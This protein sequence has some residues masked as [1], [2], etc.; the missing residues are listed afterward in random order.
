MPA[1]SRPRTSSRSRAVST[2]SAEDS[3]SIRLASRPV[4]GEEAAHA[5]GE[6]EAIVS[7]RPRGVLG[8]DQGGVEP[9]ELEADHPH[10]TAVESRLQLAQPLPDRAHPLFDLAAELLAVDQQSDAGLRAQAGIDLAQ[11]G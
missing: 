5:T 8:P 9:L 7:N 1:E 3:A 6:A 11:G 2:R 10:S 4:V